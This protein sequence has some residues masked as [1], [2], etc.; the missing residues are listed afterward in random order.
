MEIWAGVLG[1]SEIDL[2]S[3]FFEIGGNS[4]Q[5]LKVLNRI[6]AVFEIPVSLAAIFGAPTIAEQARVII[7]AV[8][9]SEKS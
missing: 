2:N 8:S 4:L 9:V 7:R 3:N 1:T 6:R 5:C